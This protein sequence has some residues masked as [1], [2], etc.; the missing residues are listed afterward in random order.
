MA[1][2]LIIED[3]TA[4]RSL[5]RDALEEAG[6]EVTEASDGDLG[7]KRFKE[8]R[9]DIVI[10]DI[11]MPKK[12]GLEVIL[13]M[14]DLSPDIKIITISGGGIGLG[15]DLL[16]ISLEFGARHALRKPVKMQHLLEVVKDVLGQ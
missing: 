7:M 9:H 6:H 10:T 2:V 8:E 15:D 12:E 4:L 11:L 16:D 13:E 1:R 5:M 3:E 14:T